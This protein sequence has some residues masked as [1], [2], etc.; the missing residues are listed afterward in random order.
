MPFKDRTTQL[1][2]F[3]EYN[4]NRGTDYWKNIND[5][6]YEY[7]KIRNYLYTEALYI[8]ALDILC[9]SENHMCFSCKENDLRCLQFDHINGGGEADRRIGMSGDTLYRWVIKNPDEAKKKFQILCSNCNWR[10]RWSEERVG[11]PKK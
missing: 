5:K 8:Y 3:K 4:K 2:Y 10:K 1:L 7:L 6:R 11:R 9:E